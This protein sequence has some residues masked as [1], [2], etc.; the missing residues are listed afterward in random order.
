MYGSLT[1]TPAFSSNGMAGFSPVTKTT[2]LENGGYK[3]GCE[4]FQVECLEIRLEQQRKLRLDLSRSNM[5][6]ISCI[7]LLSAALK[8]SLDER[9]LTGKKIP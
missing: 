6:W 1:R 9:K 5:E 2:L 3:K 8:L 7:C 4:T